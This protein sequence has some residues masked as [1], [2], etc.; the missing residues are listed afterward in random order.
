[1]QPIYIGGNEKIGLQKHD[2]YFSFHPTERYHYNIDI[3]EPIDTK[4]YSSHSEPAAVNLLTEE[5]RE[6]FESYRKNDPENPANLI[7]A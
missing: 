1:M 3:L 6:T 5:L 4:K 7:R 2:K